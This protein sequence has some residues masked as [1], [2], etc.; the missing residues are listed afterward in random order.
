[1]VTAG[2]GP[3]RIRVGDLPKNILENEVREE[4][5]LNE[6]ILHPH[7]VNRLPSAAVPDP[8]PS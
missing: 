5:A 3:V 8:L 7:P 6:R 4:G 1:M 2:Y